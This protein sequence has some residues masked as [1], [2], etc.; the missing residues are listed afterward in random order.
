V[1]AGHRR[2][3]A[4]QVSSLHCERITVFRFKL[5]LDEDAYTFSPDDPSEFASTVGSV[6]DLRPK[7]RFGLGDRV[8][9]ARAEIEAARAAASVD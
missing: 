2:L 1:V 4:W 3:G 8:R 6:I 9:A 5:H 7:S